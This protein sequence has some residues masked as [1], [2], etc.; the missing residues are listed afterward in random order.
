M[1]G[2]GLR[3]Y[4]RLGLFG[5]AVSYEGLNDKNRVFW[6]SYAVSTVSKHN[7]EPQEQYE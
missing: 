7:K 1:N 6:A 2:L 4:E 3:V 5:L